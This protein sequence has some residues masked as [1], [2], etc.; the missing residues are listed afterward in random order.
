MNGEV[1]MKNSKLLIYFTA[2]M[3]CSVATAESLKLKFVSGDKYSVVTAIDQ[4]AM[5]VI[6]GN[7][8]KTEQSLRIEC[9]LEIEEVDEQGCAWAKYTYS[10]IFMRIQSESQKLSYDSDANQSKIPMKI[11]PLKMALGESVYMRITP[12]GRVAKINGLQ[13]LIGSAKAKLANYPGA[14]KV[15]PDIIN[16]FTEPAMRRELE[17]QLAVFPDANWTGGPWCRRDVLSSVDIG[18]AAVEQTEE[19]NMMVESTFQLNP[20]KSAG[21]GIAFVDVNVVLKQESN[22][23][24]NVSLSEIAAR[25]TREIAGEGAGRIEIEEATGRIISSKI[26]RDMVEGIKFITPAHM[27]RPPRGPEPLISHTVTTFQMTKIEE[28][29]TAQPGDTN[30]KGA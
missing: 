15:L 10:R 16:Q 8:Q 24:S 30:E 5:R 9:N 13:T 23:L 25:A 18:Y 11:M 22:P 3:F 26:T 17:N 1:G 29:K 12:Q 19:V 20:K 6:D 21:N 7:E 14:E 27:I 28:G 4:N 2:A